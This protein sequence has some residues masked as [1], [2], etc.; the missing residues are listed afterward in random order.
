M[1]HFNER[2]NETLKRRVSFNGE[3]LKISFGKG[4]NGREFRS[5]ACLPAYKN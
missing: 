2:L 3:F 5:F 4:A 1:P